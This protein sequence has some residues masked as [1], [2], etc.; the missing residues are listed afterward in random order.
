MNQLAIEFESRPRYPNTSQRQLW[1]LLEALRRWEKLTVLV[2]LQKYQCYALS[3]RMG[4]LRNL[5]WPVRS[6]MIELPSGKRV[7]E[8]RLDQ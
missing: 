1:D 4:E 6:K 8:Y 5:G 2:A 7:A 3:Q